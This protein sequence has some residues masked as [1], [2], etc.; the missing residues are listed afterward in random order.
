MKWV[1]YQLK[2]GIFALKLAGFINLK[3]QQ[4]WK[5]LFEWFLFFLMKNKIVLV[6]FINKKSWNWD[7]D[8]G[9]FISW[10]IICLT[11]TWLNSFQ[12]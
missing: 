8:P 12:L 11:L 6:I 10:H 5:V 4:I 1:Q 9:S 7:I 3:S 2:N